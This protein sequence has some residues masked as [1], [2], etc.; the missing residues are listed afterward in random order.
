ME[1]K[2]VVRQT[3]NPEKDTTKA[4][5]AATQLMDIVKKNNWSKSFGGQ[6]EHIFYEGWQTVGK[7]YNMTVATGDAEPIDI[8]GVKGFKAKAWVVDNR[9]G[10]RVGEA[11]A[12]CMKDEKNWSSKPLFQL[13]SMAQTR[14]GSKALRQIFG[15]VVAL[16]GYEVTPA[17]EMTGEEKTALPGQPKTQVQQSYPISPVEMKII[18]GLLETKGKKTKDL[19]NAIKTAF[20][21]DSIQKLTLKEANALILKLKSLPDNVIEGEIDNDEAEEEIEK[22]EV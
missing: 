4:A 22:N 2:I 19:D 17:E 14:A 20:K 10:I 9:T 12:Y 6:K 16:A 18:Y 5:K 3:F 15:Y 1:N 7:Y 13:A 11:E 8:D 21:K